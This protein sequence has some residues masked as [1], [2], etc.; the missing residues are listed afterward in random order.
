MKQTLL[1]PLPIFMKRKHSRVTA[2]L[3]F[4]SAAIICSLTVWATPGDNQPNGNATLGQC[5]GAPGVLIVDPFA[6]YYSCVSLGSVP[7]VQTPYGGLTFKYND[8][9]TLL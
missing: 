9:N 4:A 7:G 1:G 6:D 5:I 8:T 2:A 3:L